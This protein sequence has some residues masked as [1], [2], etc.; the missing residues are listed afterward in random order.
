M[1]HVL[2]SSKEL[3]GYDIHA[4]WLYDYPRSI[5][6]GGTCLLAVLFKPHQ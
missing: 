2:G 3:H 6:Y 4:Q 1:A 5:G